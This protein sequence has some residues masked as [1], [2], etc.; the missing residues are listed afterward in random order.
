MER[1]NFLWGDGTVQCNVQ[2]ECN[3]AWSQITLSS[4][5]IDFIFIFWNYKYVVHLQLNE[6]LRAASVNAPI[7]S[8]ILQVWLLVV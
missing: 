7:P 1:G 2:R 3:V 4:F 6:G 5:V 8:M